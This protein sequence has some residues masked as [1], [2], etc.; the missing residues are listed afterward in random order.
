MEPNDF[1][2]FSSFQSSFFLNNYNFAQLKW[3]I[4]EKIIFCPS[5][6]LLAENIFLE[7]GTT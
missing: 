7:N 6:V 2:D 5:K 4:F 1:L 3:Y